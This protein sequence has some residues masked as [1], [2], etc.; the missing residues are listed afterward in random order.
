MLR[1]ILVGLDGSAHS[2]AATE[3]GIRWA[4]QFDA[5][6][7][8]LGIIDEPSLRSSQPVPL[9]AGHFKEHLDETRLAQATRQVEQFLEQF[10]L[11]CTEAGVSSKVLEN[12]GTPYEQI[13][14]EAQRYDLILLGQQTH[15]HFATGDSTGETLRQVIRNATRPVITVPAHLGECKTVL[16]AYDGS[17]QAARA[18]QVFEATG[19]GRSWPVH[20]VNVSDD[21]AEARRQAERAADFLRAHDIVAEIHTVHGSPAE[22]VLK[23][24]ETVGAGLVVMGAYG[25]RTLR[26]FFLGSATRSLLE[27]APLPLFLYH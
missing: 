23:Q 12:Q 9:G 19:L 6:V 22:A 20:I 13:L 1:T 18:L 3:L 14:L 8:G 27:K 15:F 4:G 5:L 24:A 16:I 11:R 2:R 25:Q 17:L 10:T 26:E 21:L 7:V